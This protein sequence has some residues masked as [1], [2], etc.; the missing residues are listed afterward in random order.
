MRS[1]GRSRSQAAS[2][3]TLIVRAQAGDREA[4]DELV[5]RHFAPV[6]RMLHRRVGNHED[7][8]DLAQECFV[9]AWGALALYRAEAP[10]SAW[11]LGVTRRTIASRFKRKRHEMVPLGDDDPED[12]HPAYVVPSVFDKRVAAAVAGAVADA[13]IR[14][15]VVRSALSAAAD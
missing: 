7:A 14:E 1:A 10:F 15:G 3:A 5:R 6:Y 4:F 11:V 9:R 2:D 13:A 8:E 12:L